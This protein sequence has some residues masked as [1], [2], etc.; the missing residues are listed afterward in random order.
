MTI[1]VTLAESRRTG[2]IISFNSC[3]LW[4]T[5]DVVQVSYCAPYENANSG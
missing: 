5:Q 2:V 3:L 1:P 4:N